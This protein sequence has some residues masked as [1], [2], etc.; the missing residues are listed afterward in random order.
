MMRRILVDAARKRIAD[1]RG[2]VAVRVNLDEIPEIG[3]HR[4]S[5]LIAL[6]DALNALGEVDPRKSDRDRDAFLR[7]P[8][9]GRSQCGVEDF[10]AKCDAG[11]EARQGLAPART[12]QPGLLISSG[13]R[14][15]PICYWAVLP[16]RVPTTG[17]SS[18]S[19]SA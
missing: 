6:D 8:L 14:R 10:A 12:A 5:E 4:A 11:L 7:R 17:Q 15:N 9:G 16:R 2:G 13:T 1:K 18:I 19:S 3:T